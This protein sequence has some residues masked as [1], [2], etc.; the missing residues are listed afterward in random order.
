MKNIKV[1]EPFRTNG[2]PATAPIFVIGVI[3]V[4]AAA[5]HSVVRKIDTASDTLGVFAPFDMATPRAAAGFGV[6]AD[7][8]S[9]AHLDCIPAFASAKE[10]RSPVLAL[11]FSDDGQLGEFRSDHAEIIRQLNI[12]SKAVLRT[13]GLIAT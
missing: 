2:N 13:F 10:D 6:P 11:S 9:S 8:V 1:R 5:L 4:V 12:E 3:L 7:Q